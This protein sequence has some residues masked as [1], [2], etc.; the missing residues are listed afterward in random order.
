MFIFLER[1]NTYKISY[2]NFYNKLIFKSNYF[3]YYI[4]YLIR[5]CLFYFKRLKDKDDENLN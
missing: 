5:I 3:L 4:E 2:S 1:I